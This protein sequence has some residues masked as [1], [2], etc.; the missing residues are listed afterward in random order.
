M[1]R[2]GTLSYQPLNVSAFHSIM[3]FT[4]IRVLRF[5]ILLGALLGLVG[6]VSA[7][8]SKSPPN[9]VIGSDEIVG[10]INATS[11][12]NQLVSG[13]CP[14]GGGEFVP[15]VVADPVDVQN[16][17]PGKLGRAF[18]DIFRSAL[19]KACGIP[20]RQVELSKDF[21]LSG[22][23]ITALT[24]NLS[25]VRGESFRAKD[26]VITTY[27][28]NAATIYFVSRRIDV[29]TGSIHAMSTR[30]VSWQCEQD[31]LGSTKIKTNIR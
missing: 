23:G 2:I 19:F 20:I 27:S 29:S 10:R 8:T 15:L 16:Y 24:R 17:L 9:C 12:A 13:L 3:G 31:L 6:C 26:A 4:M 28:S 22:D 7:P 5:V 14:T 25:D 1:P 11:L 18:G 21:G 30:E